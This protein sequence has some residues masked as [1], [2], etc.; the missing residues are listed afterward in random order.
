MPS[1]APSAPRCSHCLLLCIYFFPDSR[2]ACS[3]MSVI[4]AHVVTNKISRDLNYVVDLILLIR[5]CYS[6]MYIREVINF[7]AMPSTSPKLLNLNPKTTT[8]KKW[9][10]LSNSYKI[11][12]LFNFIRI[13][14][15]KP[16]F[17]SGGLGDQVQYLGLVLGMAL[18]F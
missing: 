10:F 12:V 17:L 3:G 7:K 5:F 15:E 8:Q 14:Q 1:Q 16:I 11:E 6:S 9:F 18:K 4:S 13:W 2:F